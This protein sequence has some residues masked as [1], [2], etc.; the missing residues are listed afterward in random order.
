MHQFTHNELVTDEAAH[1]LSA[2]V[3]LCDRCALSYPEY[4]QVT[5]L[6]FLVIGQYEW[7]ASF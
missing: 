7:L 4:E 3:L 6:F 1:R 5:N 2:I